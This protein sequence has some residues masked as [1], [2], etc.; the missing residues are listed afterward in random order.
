M[1]I[2]IVVAAMIAVAGL[3]VCIERAALRQYA[4]LVAE[5]NGALRQLAHGTDLPIF[6]SSP[7]PD[8]RPAF[9]T[10]R[11]TYRGRH[12]SVSV[13]YVATD[14]IAT[15]LFV[16]AAS[17]RPDFDVSSLESTADEVSDNG[18]GITLIFA[19]RKTFWQFGFLT[20]DTLPEKD[21]VRL[22]AALDRACDALGP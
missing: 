22:R 10:V 7:P 14:E 20:Y 16:S 5:T 11:G 3:V 12:V 13:A 6:E 21:T 18:K 19:P 1:S 2:V 8:A 15:S 4:E 9:A 17:R